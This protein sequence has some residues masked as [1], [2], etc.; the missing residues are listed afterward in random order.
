MYND[1]KSRKLY[2]VS[3]LVTYPFSIPNCSPSP[4]DS[5]YLDPTDIKAFLRL[6]S[7]SRRYLYKANTKI[8]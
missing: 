5:G 7:P 4:K 6:V 3:Q 8:G 2:I 1:F